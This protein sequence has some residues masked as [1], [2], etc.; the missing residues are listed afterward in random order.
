M[1]I[2]FD[3]FDPNYDIWEPHIGD[4]DPAPI[5]N[6]ELIEAEV[7]GLPGLC[8]LCTEEPPDIPD[9]PQQASAEAQ[10]QQLQDQTAQP[11]LTEYPTYVQVTGEEVRAVDLGPFGT[12]D[13]N[14]FMAVPLDRLLEH[15]STVY[16]RSRWRQY[17]QTGH[18]F[19]GYTGP[20]EDAP[21]G[22]HLRWWWREV[23]HEK[24]YRRNAWPNIAADVPLA[25]VL[26]ELPIMILN[27]QGS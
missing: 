27:P 7:L 22:E 20:S 12:V 2:E 3:V 19:R 26:P 1:G 10:D 5:V 4:I 21:I 24:H 14:K 15:M 8:P 23:V 25:D 6:S 11:S 17:E 18:F 9:L 16:Q 13:P